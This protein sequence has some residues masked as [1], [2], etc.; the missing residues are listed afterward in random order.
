MGQPNDA[1]LQQVLTQEAEPPR[2]GGVAKVEPVTMLEALRRVRGD[3]A[4]PTAGSR[5]LR[6]DEARHG[7]VRCDV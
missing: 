5:G 1:A 2:C 7:K 6:G 4:E 3:A